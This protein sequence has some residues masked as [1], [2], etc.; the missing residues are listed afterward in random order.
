[1]N[2]AAEHDDAGPVERH[3]RIHVA[4]VQLQLEPLRLGERVD[5]MAHVVA[6]REG[7]LGARLYDE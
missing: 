4:F 7:D 1:V 6:V 5:V 3:R 2:V